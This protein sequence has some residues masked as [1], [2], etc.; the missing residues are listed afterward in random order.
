MA[1][2]EFFSAVWAVYFSFVGIVNTYNVCKYLLEFIILN[3]SS[4]VW[5]IANIYENSWHQNHFYTWRLEGWGAGG[6]VRISCALCHIFE[7]KRKL[8]GGGVLHGNTPRLPLPSICSLCQVG[9]KD[10]YPRRQHCRP[11]FLMFWGLECKIS[12]TALA[13][14]LSVKIFS[15]ASVKCFQITNGSAWL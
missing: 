14:H 15:N 5:D 12:A 1:A 10:L 6:R 7:R 8:V 13:P 9:S 11:C 3:Y 4:L 2:Q